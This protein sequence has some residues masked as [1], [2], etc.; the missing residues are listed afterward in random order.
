MFTFVSSLTR[1][2]ANVLMFVGIARMY[3]PEEFGRFTFAH[4]CLTL[5][6]LVADF[7]ID[8]LLTTEVPRNKARTEDLVGRL[9]PLK[10]FFA[11]I[12]L[13]GFL[14]L[15]LLS[16][17]GSETRNLFLGL[18]IAI[19][20]NSMA[21]FFFALCKAKEQMQHETRITFIQSATLIITILS[22]AAARMPLVAIAVVFSVTRLFG[23]FLIVRFVRKDYG[24]NLKGITIAD[25]R[26][27]LTASLPF[28]L[29]YI[30]GTL[31]FQIDTVLLGYWTNDLS[32]GIYQAVVRIVAMILMISDVLVTATIPVLARTHA[33]DTTRWLRMSRILGKTL[34]FIGLPFGVFLYLFADQI[35]AMVY[36]VGRFSAAV[37]ILRVFAFIVMIR[38]A[39]EVYALMLT[40]GSQ[41]RIRTYIVVGMTFFNIALNATMIPRFGAEGAAVVSLLTNSMGFALY[42][43]AARAR[44]APL[45]TPVDWRS[46]CVLI[47][48][49]V[50]VTLYCTLN[51]SS[52]MIGAPII[53]TFFLVT[54]FLLG[55]SKEERSLVVVFSTSF[56]G[57]L[58]I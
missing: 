38:F 34:L 30:F 29:F 48:T 41:Q 43:L 7:G 10:M 45:M 49:A 52:I 13:V 47:A 3:G 11:G 18:S 21:N 44:L 57:R 53:V 8:L 24:V 15:P 6:F 51:V 4:T 36:G 35:L 55:F 54:Y 40:T 22:M 42:F 26:A 2:G 20:G 28:G 27:T 33:S 19:L 46:T 37:P 39:A 31:F 58:H 9:L 12:A 25:W 50:F 14:L 56:R 23:A 5:F 32:V 1:M 17:F 16:R